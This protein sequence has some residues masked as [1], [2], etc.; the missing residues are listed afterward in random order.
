MG[1][2]TVGAE[3][4]GA[5]SVFCNCTGGQSPIFFAYIRRC[6]A[7]LAHR[8]LIKTYI[9]NQ[10]EL[11]QGSLLLMRELHF[12]HKHDKKKTE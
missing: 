5:E 9:E 12:T 10:S 1:A 2:E 6:V 11:Q 3:T 7:A 8:E 4:V